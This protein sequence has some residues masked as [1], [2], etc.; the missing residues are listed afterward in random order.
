[1][2]SPFLGI[3]NILNE[4]K[5]IIIVGLIPIHH[6]QT[7]SRD[8]Y[9]VLEFEW[10]DQGDL[11]MRGGSLQGRE[12]SRLEA[13]GE[14]G[15]A[16]GAGKWASSPWRPWYAPIGVFFK[17]VAHILAIHPATCFDNNIQK[18]KREEE[19]T[20]TPYSF[21]R[22]FISWIK[23]RLRVKCHS[24]SDTICLPLVTLN[25]SYIFGLT[26]FMCLEYSS[27]ARLP[28]AN[29]ATLTR[30]SPRWKGGNKLVHGLSRVKGVQ[31]IYGV[32]VCVYARRTFYKDSLDF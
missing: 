1:M 4:W 20:K 17:G 25:T 10:P 14:E 2:K 9:M 29:N 8:V 13:Y 23:R 32:R 18:K 3:R 6:S 24:R 16:K 26:I 11:G 12:E 27:E 19:E 21:L 31:P 7:S 22:L 5:V 28:S 30:N 15:A